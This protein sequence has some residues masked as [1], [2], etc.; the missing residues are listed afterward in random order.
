MSAFPN[1]KSPS[2]N[3][4]LAAGGEIRGREAGR[5]EDGTGRFAAAV[6]RND[7]TL[8]NALSRAGHETEGAA[9]ARRKA[10]KST[11]RPS[12]EGL[13]TTKT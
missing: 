4:K 12:V 7:E 13:A 2:T 10:K 3:K 8:K 6:L 11:T 9:N 1:K 5:G